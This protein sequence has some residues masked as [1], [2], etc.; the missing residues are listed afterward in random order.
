[1]DLRQLEYLVAVV[2]E[3]SFTRAAARVHI[4]QS[5]V[6]AQ[7]RQLE[8][9]LGAELIDRSGRTARPTAAGRAALEP[10]RAALAAA[11]AVR[12][13]VD[14]VTGVV[15]GRLALGMVSGCTITPL[16]DALARFRAA[17]P[18][19]EVALREDDSDA[20]LAAL[21]AGALDVALVGTADEP[22]DG[23]A[24][25]VVLREPLVVAVPTAHPLAGRRSLAPGE[26]VGHPLVALPRG[27]GIRTVLDRAAAA[28][29]VRLAPELEA[30]APD[31][32]LDLAERGLGAAVVSASMLAGRE[33]LRGIPLAGSPT[34]AALA[35]AWRPAAAP[36]AARF[37]ALARDAFGD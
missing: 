13:A 20:L 16:F 22:L 27:T 17:H 6:S 24:S 26:L 18:G 11:A 25:H 21:R 1:M 31:A 33:R 35:L 23:V 19:V 9:E 15:R 5:G 10:A 30:S 4:S 32:I 3:A 37:V 34:L 28:A 2:D 36:A 29:D 12:R 14:D 7:V 8:R